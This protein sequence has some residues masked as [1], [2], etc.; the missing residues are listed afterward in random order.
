MLRSG[1]SL[2]HAM[3]IFEGYCLPHAICKLSFGGKDLRDFMERLLMVEHGFV[4]NKKDD[5][6]S[7]QIIKQLCYIAQGTLCAICVVSYLSVCIDLFLI[8]FSL[9]VCVCVFNYAHVL[10][11]VARSTG[12]HS[13]EKTHTHT[14]TN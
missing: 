14:P 11:R 3:P 7:Q 4:T 10:Q 5:P 1:H 6:I 9:C 13:P 12:Q 2:T 8:A